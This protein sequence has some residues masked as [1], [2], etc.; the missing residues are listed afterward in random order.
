MLNGD[1]QYRVHYSYG[2]NSGTMIGPNVGDIVHR[3]E[4]DTMGR[5]HV[6]KIESR[7]LTVIYTEW[8]EQKNE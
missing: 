1:I 6:D 3:V 5:I 7:I 2:V 4:T 8:E